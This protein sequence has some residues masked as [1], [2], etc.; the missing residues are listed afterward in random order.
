M[1]LR[2]GPKVL[3]S[4]VCLTA[5]CGQPSREGKPVCPEHVE[6]MA[7]AQ[8]VMDGIHEGELLDAMVRQRRGGPGVDHLVVSRG[9]LVAHAAKE[10]V[11]ALWTH[12]RKTVPGLAREIDRTPEV[13]ECYAA[14]L[15][16]AGIMDYDFNSRSQKRVLLVALPE[17]MRWLDTF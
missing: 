12:G 11:V 6:T 5:G 8:Q 1:R 10:L 15:K 3:K 13:T 7:Y 14:V 17:E 16:R 2:P 4:S 9:H